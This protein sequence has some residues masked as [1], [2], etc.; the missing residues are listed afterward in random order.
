MQFSSAKDGTKL[1]PYFI[2]RGAAFIGT[3]ENRSNIVSN[4]LKYRLSDS[5]GNECPPEEKVFMT[6]NGA[7]N[8]NRY[9]TIG[10]FDRAIF[11]L[12]ES[13]RRKQRS[14]FIRRFKIP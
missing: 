9:L 10:I 11:S 5:H 12:P 4:K 3:R 1:I 6:C 14:Y 7:G 2:L 8:S 13:P